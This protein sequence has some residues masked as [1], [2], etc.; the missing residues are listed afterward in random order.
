MPLVPVALQGRS[1]LPARPRRQAEPS[2]GNATLGLGTFRLS[3]S[4]HF[5][6]ARCNGKR[7]VEQIV[8]ELVSEYDVDIRT[9]RRDV[10]A[11]LRLY[12]QVG[13]IA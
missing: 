12:Q 7:T 5:I 9:A 4:A 10:R 1:N 2:D 8:A 3:E 13:L 6:L 11:C